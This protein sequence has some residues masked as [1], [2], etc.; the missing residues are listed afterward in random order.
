MALNWTFSFASSA[1]STIKF[2][3]GSFCQP[4]AKTVHSMWGS[5]PLPR[6]LPHHWSPSPWGLDFMKTFWN[7]MLALFCPSMY[8]PQTFYCPYM[9]S[10]LITTIYIP[11]IECLICARHCFNQAIQPTGQ[12]PRLCNQIARGNLVLQLISGVIPRHVFNFFVPQFSY[13]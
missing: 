13:V 3:G 11:F 4:L 8:T 12:S 9:F 10:F 1:T 5:L 6:G 2:S 7:W